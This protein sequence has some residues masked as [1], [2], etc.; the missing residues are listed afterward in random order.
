[1]TVIG[2]VKKNKMVR[3]LF[4][5]DLVSVGWGD[6]VGVCACASMASFSSQQMQFCMRSGGRACALSLVRVCQVARVV[7]CVG[8]VGHEL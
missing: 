7:L 2:P 1:M 5:D 8:I 3:C 4:I 6:G